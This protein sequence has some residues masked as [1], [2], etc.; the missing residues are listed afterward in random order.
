M[1]HSHLCALL[2]D[3]NV[4]DVDAAAGFWAA[5]LGWPVD[6]A[7]PSSRGQYRMLETPPDEPIVEIQRVD[8][9]SR[10]H[11]DIE[12]DDIPA[13]VQRLENLGATV[14]ER[15]ARWV[16]MQ[17]PTGQ[18]FCVVRAQRPG[19]AENANRWD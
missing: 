12:T 13:E 16:V 14:V 1:H 6:L 17:A 11:I 5:A 3:C 2:I 7:H 10:V 15:L 9:E 18:C 8:H 4:P 19:F